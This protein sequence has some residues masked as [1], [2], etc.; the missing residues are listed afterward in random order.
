MKPIKR[1]AILG[2]GAMGAYFAACFFSN[3]AFTTEL[4]ADGTRAE[5]LISNGLIV[6]GKKLD[7]PV[8]NPSNTSEPY[9]LII[10][11]LKHHQL[12]PALTTLHPLV[13]ENTLFISVMNGLESESLIATEFGWDHVLYAISVGIDAVRKNNCI[14]YTKAGKH[15]FGEANNE[16]LSSKVCRV[17][18]AFTAAGIQHETPIDMLRTLWWKFMV[19]VGVNQASA[20]LH[21]PYGVFHTDPNARGLMEALMQE[22]VLLAQAS[23][24]N[25]THQDILNWYPVLH[26]LSAEGKTSMLQDVEASRQTEVDVFAGKVIELGKTHNIP[27]PVNQTIM[28][29]IKVIEIYQLK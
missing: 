17:Q 13:G 23:G 15:L 22:V 21:A 8:S 9:D 7:I 19:N 29:I 5:K 6:N 3:P 18:E 12:S 1:V 2:A 28:Q 20:V 10:I 16:V 11:A 27:T 25:L 24:I 14:T 4:I 26:T